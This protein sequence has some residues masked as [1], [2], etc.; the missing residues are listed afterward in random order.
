MFCKCPDPRVSVVGW[1][2]TC[3]VV[4]GVKAVRLAR[5]PRS[6]PWSRTFTTVAIRCVLIGILSGPGRDIYC[7][8]R[9]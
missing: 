8:I 5:R 2:V 1:Y 7:K 9:K 4:V 3:V 6:R